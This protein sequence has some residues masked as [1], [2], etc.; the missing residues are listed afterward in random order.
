ML[1]IENVLGEGD[2]DR[3]GHTL[4]VIMLAV[5]GGRERTGEQLGGLLEG[6][7]FTDSRVIETAGPLRIVESVA[8]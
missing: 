2:V 6:A 7:G 4:D 1:I 8:G 3:R 5:T